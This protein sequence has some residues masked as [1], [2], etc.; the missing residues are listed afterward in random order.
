MLSLSIRRLGLFLGCVVLCLG[1]SAC[2]AA[3]ESKGRLIVW[4]TWEEAEAPIIEQILADFQR[5]HPN[6]EISVQRKAYDTVLDEFAEAARAGLGPDALIGLESVYAHLLYEEGLAADL[7]EAEVDWTLFHPA[8]LQSV[9][10]GRDV[11]VGVPLNAYVSV[12]FFNRSLIERPPTSLDE[13]L[14]VSEEGVEVGLPTTFFASYWG[15]TALDGSVFDGDTLS[16][17]TQASFSNWFNWLITFQQTP[18]AVLSP[19]VRALSDSFA[20]GDIALLVAN[21]LELASLEEKLGSANVGVATLPGFPQAQPFSNVELIVINSASVQMEAAALLSNFM[22]NAAQQRKLARSTS[23]RAPVNREVN[24]NP[25][26]F[27]RVSMILRQN[28]AAVVPTRQQDELI[29]QLI[30][31]ADPIFQQVVEGLIAP[32]AG[33]QRIVDAVNSAEEGQ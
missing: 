32:T 28:Q 11:R 2:T 13:L 14:A 27:P 33:A 25:T 26:L 30:V 12:L 31:A 17:N 29:N 8:T 9:Q 7:S 3:P 15:I 1:L 5:L 24:L 19:D 23:G 4:H 6:V 16:A 18:G 22:G 21:S 10:R 20:Q